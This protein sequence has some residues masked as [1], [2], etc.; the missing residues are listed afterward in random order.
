[1]KASLRIPTKEPY[2]FIEVNSEGTPAE[3]FAEYQTMTNIVNGTE[4]IP[5]VYESLKN[6]DF[7][8][9]LDKYLSTSHLEAQEYEACD[10]LQKQVLQTIK[11]AFKRIKS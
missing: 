10:E 9:V 1:M 6:L 5:T 7:N 3:V 4:A 8:K 2:A 11:R